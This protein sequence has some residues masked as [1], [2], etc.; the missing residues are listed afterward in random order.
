[1]L[2]QLESTNEEKIL[3]LIRGID[4]EA[5]RIQLKGLNYTNT[6]DLLLKMKTLSSELTVN[7]QEKRKDLPSPQVHKSGSDSQRVNVVRCYSRGKVAHVSRDCPD[8][9][10]GTKCFLCQNFGHKS[11]NCPKRSTRNKV[12]YIEM[13]SKDHKTMKINNIKL[14]ALIDTGTN[15]NLI[16]QRRVKTTSTPNF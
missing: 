12:N 10:K 8:K 11:L 14:T 1:M 5:L 3:H 4:N 6:D 16:V 13:K 7:H 9:S 2:N 15:L